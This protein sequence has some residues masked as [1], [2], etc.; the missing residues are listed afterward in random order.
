MCYY[1]G[2]WSLGRDSMPLFTESAVREITFQ[3][4]GGVER[5]FFCMRQLN[6]RPVG[7]AAR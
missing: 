4:D 1:G 6:C 7:E 3:K 5:S 2:R